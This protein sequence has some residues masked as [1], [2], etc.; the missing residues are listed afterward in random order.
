MGISSSE[1]NFSGRRS[2]G[3]VPFGSRNVSSSTTDNP[4]I[5][6][7]ALTIPY[8]PYQVDMAY[9]KSM[10]AHI[11][12]GIHDDI[13]DPVW[14]GWTSGTIATFCGLPYSWAT[15]GSGAAKT[16]AYAFEENPANV[17]VS[18]PWHNVIYENCSSI[19]RWGARAFNL[20]FP[21]GSDED[22]FFLTLEVYKRTLDYPANVTEEDLYPEASMVCRWKGFKESIKALL[23][24]TM[25]PDGRLAM[26]DSCNVM[27]YHPTNR[28]YNQ[29]RLKSNALWDSF[30]GKNSVKDAQYYAYLDAWITDLKWINDHSTSIGVTA[31]G[32]LYITLDATSPAATP[33]NIHHWRSMSDYRS[34]A[35][36]LAD[37]YVFDQLT[38][39][40]IAVFYE[41]RSEKTRDHA[42]IG[43]QSWSV[44]E[45][46]IGQ[47]LPIQWAGKAFAAE[48]YWFWFSNPENPS[49]NT[50]FSNHVTD[51]DTPM[52]SRMILSNFPVY[53]AERDPYGTI[54][55]AVFGGITRDLKTPVDLNLSA[56][57]TPQFCM[58][59]YYAL[60][61]HYRKAYNDINAQ[62]STVVPFTGIA[63]NIKNIITYFPQF[64]MDGVMVQSVINNVDRNPKRSYYDVP[65][66]VGHYRPGFDQDHWLMTTHPYDHGLWT[67]EG[68]LSYDIN[69]RAVTFNYF[70]GKLHEYSKHFGPSNVN[71]DWTGFTYGSVE[72]TLTRDVIV[73]VEQEPVVVD[74]PRVYTDMWAATWC[75]ISSVSPI[76]TIFPEQLGGNTAADIVPGAISGV[77]RYEFVKPMIHLIGCYTDGGYDDE[78][79]Q[80]FLYQANGCL[81]ANRRLNTILKLKSLPSGKRALK[82]TRYDQGN[83]FN[84][85]SDT[86]NGYQQPWALYAGA[87]VKNDWTAIA[88]TL[89]TEGG[90]V[91]QLI[92]DGSPTE[93]NPFEFFSMGTDAFVTSITGNP[94]A[95]Q[96][97]KGSRSF[98]YL[99]GNSLNY[100]SV[101][102]Q[103]SHPQTNKKYLYW[104]RAVNSIMSAFVNEYLIKPAL[105]IF[106]VTKA[107]NYESVVVKSDTLI[108][109]RW[110]HPFMMENM[111]GD[112]NAPQIYGAWYDPNNTIGIKNSDTTQLVRTD[113]AA[114]TSFDDSAW[115]RFLLMMQTLRGV[116]RVSP[117]SP[118]RPWIAPVQWTGETTDPTC[119]PVWDTDAA[120]TKLYWE[121]I[122]HALI[123][124]SDNLIYWNHD[125]ETVPDRDANCATL[126]TVIRE[127]NI[128]IGGYTPHAT[129]TDRIDFLAQYVVSGAPA[130]NGK[131][132]W[133]ITP[134]PTFGLLDADSNPIV[135][136]QHGGAWRSTNTS[137]PPVFTV[138]S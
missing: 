104:N 22:S 128:H 84:N 5:T 56:L 73:L 43:G 97:W 137:T 62:T 118:M 58:W 33:D 94:L 30:V 111:I 4:P 75:G 99:Y 116:K 76:Q 134:K 115:S 133:R 68:I 54:T 14:N 3:R 70:I 93:N 91:D 67:Q 28:G 57:W 90:K 127:V 19:Y 18:S 27:L 49:V 26:T 113:F 2:L 45:G 109:D 135:F 63:A 44:E 8:N 39:A 120:S 52:V 95:S 88:T 89:K 132:L 106:D 20:F 96:S 138:V 24:G 107:S 25:A 119:A 129:N 101:L 71:S 47:V 66:R 82:M 98:N 81:G 1:N 131:Y 60:S 108:Y 15:A 7:R 10:F 114:T 51:S 32:K 11:G 23:E 16:R 121:L 122:R 64:I 9:N 100:D 37:W 123:T 55:T 31:P 41:S 12:M 110:G 13:L 103:T 74:P 136:D 40:G 35:L 38:K 21:F 117:D 50:D 34:D 87:V 125:D 53:H 77:N 79:T 36:E 17:N 59:H 124:G 72:D 69:V 130:P 83:Y 42:T 78:S 48:E 86:R 85:A 92:F 112:A 65:T 61:D 102:N 126:D 29:Y 80:S 6:L 46:D 105:V